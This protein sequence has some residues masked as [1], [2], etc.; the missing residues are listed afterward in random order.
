VHYQISKAHGDITK[1][2][3]QGKQKRHPKERKE[4]KTG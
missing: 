1:K 3:N 4:K 2:Q